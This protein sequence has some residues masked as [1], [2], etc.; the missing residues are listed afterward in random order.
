MTR[1]TFITLE[2]GEGSGKSTQA[3]R[4]AAALRAA[5]REVVETREPG[6][7]P[8][9]E[10]IRALLVEGEPG[11]WTPMT[12]ALLHFAARADHVARLIGPALD[13]GAVVV[14]DRFVDSTIA[15]QGAGQGVPDEALTML[16]TAVLGKLKPDLTLVYD[17]PVP[18]GLARAAARRNGAARY[19]SMG[20]AFHETV[21]KAF[22]AFARNEP[23]RCVVVDATADVDEVARRTLAAVSTRLGLAL[24]AAS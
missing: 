9:A 21:R 24:R 4:L 13:R 11:R 20:P 6:G 12:E 16:N 22:L 7:T 15:Y 17:L 3:R 23:D 1:G 8:G 2:G 19:E 14:C 18:V 5:G 10:A